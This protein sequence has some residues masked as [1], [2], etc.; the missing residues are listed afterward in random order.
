MLVNEL[1]TCSNETPW[2]EFK[3]NN[4]VPETIGED[5]CALSNGAVLEDRAKAYFIWGID[6][7]T[8]DI[9]GTKENLQSLRKGQQELENWLRSMLSSNVDFE[10]N[11]VEIEENT[12]G[13][14]SITAAI[15]YPA[16]F[17]NTE[18]VRIG[19]YT[20]KLKDFKTVQIRL[21]Q[22]LQSSNFESLVAKENLSSTDALK[23]LD[24]T[25]Y[26]D[27]T[28]INQPS[29]DEEVCHYLSEDGLVIRQD[30]GQY[31]IT[32]LGAVLFAK[33]LSLFP[34]V[35]RKA[36][37]VIKYKDKSRY[38]IQKEETVNKG[39]AVVF[40]DIIRYVEALTPTSEPIV[41]GFREKY[42]AFPMIAVREVLANALIHQDF[43]IT[44]VGVTVEIFDGR[45]EVTN[46][47]I[48]LIDIN[49]IVDNPPK[50]RNENLSSLMRRMH[51]CEE[52]GTGWDK[53]VLDCEL[54]QLASPQ[55][56]IYDGNTRVTLFSN[57]DFKNM[58]LED[59]FWSI[60]LHACVLYIQGEKLTNSSLRKR[61]G[62]PDS[63]SG[64]VSRLIKKSVE[65]GAIKPFNTDTANRYMQYEPFWA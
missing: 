56:K 47:G 29:N 55:I 65:R 37:R 22:K 57:T 60:Y 14:L 30:N 25:S 11:T 35:K 43:S 28:G 44:G 54:K 52:L 19:S 21:W 2:L 16:V 61:F 17:Q 42:T 62:L 24:Y 4:Y 34:S 46:P 13:V 36:L 10:Y 1:R 50:S 7:K 49:R 8:H 12:V 63:S 27:L 51:I 48:P 41:N 23:L 20:K 6:D 18:Y 31:A 9:V 5:I 3:C 39:Y 64:S 58:T 38:E 26:F 15:G 59:K 40:E 32:N 33:N 53:I 45:M